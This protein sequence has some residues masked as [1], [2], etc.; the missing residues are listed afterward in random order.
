MFTLR[1][2]KEKVNTHTHSVYISK[3]QIVV[4]NRNYSVYTIF[5]TAP[6]RCQTNIKSEFCRFILNFFFSF[7]SSVFFFHFIVLLLYL[8]WAIK[9]WLALNNKAIFHQ[10]RSVEIMM[11]QENHTVI[12]WLF[13]FFS[14][15]TF[16]T[17]FFS[18][19]FETTTYG[20]TF[21]FQIS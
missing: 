21:I 20:T 15:M 1:W 14:K 12:L 18:V 9:C 17:D 10:C 2:R 11:I 7:S 19:Y 4:S 8:I 13:C 3:C 16:E 6:F 5:C